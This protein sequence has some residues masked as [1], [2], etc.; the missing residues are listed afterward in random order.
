MLEGWTP[1][2]LRPPAASGSRKSS[3]A[4]SFMEL[5]LSFQA[6]IFLPEPSDRVASDEAA[7]FRE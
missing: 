1:L 6:K 3:A 4:M 7:P 5:S 2:T